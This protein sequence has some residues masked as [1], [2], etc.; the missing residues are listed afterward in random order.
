MLLYTHTKYMLVCVCVC[1]RA[2]VCECV[3][4]FTNITEAL[5]I[6]GSIK[7]LRNNFIYPGFIV[8]ISCFVSIHNDWLQMQFNDNIRISLSKPNRYIFP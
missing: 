7:C 2:L 5:A 1:V 6:Y 4:V 8:Q 3:C